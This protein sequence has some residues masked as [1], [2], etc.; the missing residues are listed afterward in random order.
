MGLTGPARTGN[1]H[2]LSHQQEVKYPLEKREHDSLKC[3]PETKEN[4]SRTV[5]ITTGSPDPNELR[6]RTLSVKCQ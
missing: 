3:Y 2:T 1:T 6:R 5:T 4:S